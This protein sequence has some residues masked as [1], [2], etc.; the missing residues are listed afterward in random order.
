VADRVREDAAARMRH[1]HEAAAYDKWLRVEIQAAQADAR[2]SVPHKEA[3]QRVRAHLDA[4]RVKTE[5]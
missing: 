5:T 4:L 2:T 3:M 1:A